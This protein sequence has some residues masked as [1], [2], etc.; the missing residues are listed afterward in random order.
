MTARELD[1]TQLPF[2]Q[3]YGCR[4]GTTIDIGKYFGGYHRPVQSMIGAQLFR[5]T[6]DLGFVMA[7][8]VRDG[9]YKLGAVW[10]DWSEY[11]WYAGGWGSGRNAHI[12]N[13]VRMM[14]PILREQSHSSFALRHEAPEVFKDVVALDT[15]G[16]GIYQW[17]D[18]PYGGAVVV[19]VRGLIL[20]GAVSGLSEI[21]NESFA[22][23]TL[24]GI[25][26]QILKGDGLMA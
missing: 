3:Q 15:R 17:G 4:N 13:A 23:M 2:R 20:V 25:A 14:R 22:N 16:N 11:V 26:E 7:P 10:D 21:Q 18:L 1:V 8:P 9:E 12:A 6:V 19:E 5:R 24:S